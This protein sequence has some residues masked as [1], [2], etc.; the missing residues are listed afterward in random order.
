MKYGRQKIA[1]PS[2]FLKSLTF[3]IFIMSILIAFPV[4]IAT[5]A[6]LGVMYILGL[7]L[8]C[9]TGGQPSYTSQSKGNGTMNDHQRRMDEYEQRMEEQEEKIHRQQEQLDEDDRGNYYTDRPDYMN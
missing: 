7:M 3:F 5:V 6:L 2:P 8:T 4:I 1:K 9:F